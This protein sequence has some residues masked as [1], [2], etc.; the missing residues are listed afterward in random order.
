[1]AAAMMRAA[2]P[3][4]AAAALVFSLG[5]FGGPVL[6]QLPPGSGLG[7]EMVV[8]MSELER[9]ISD[10]TGRVEELQF[11]N[12]QLADQLERAL[13]DI[14]FRLGDL[15]GGGSGDLGA[16]G[17]A[18]APAAPPPAA[19]QPPGGFDVMAPPPAE[20][21]PGLLGVVPPAEP[22]RGLLPQGDPTAEYGNAYA[23]LEQRDFPGAEAAF[24][25]FL[26]GNPGHPLAGN[27]Q[28]WLGETY[29][30]RGRFNE[31]A[32]AF[33]QNYQLYPTG[34]KAADSLL[35][36]GMS[37]A[38]LGQRTDACQI[39]SQLRVE[40]PS[41]STAVLRRAEQER[42]RLQCF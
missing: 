22:A 31:A 40:F 10:L 36:L 7:P 39:Y 42:D 24:Q 37:L 1:M 35:K 2:R 11:Q 8:R 28:Y 20:P 38:A 33:A 12:R 30:V 18:A 41:A 19:P 13:N 5:A 25:R 3:A 34:P 26:R 15:E 21:P 14:E 23:L 6:A 16:G 27:A 9:Q 4:A 29:Y 32:V 17:G